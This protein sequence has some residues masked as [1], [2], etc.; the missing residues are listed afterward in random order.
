MHAASDSNDSQFEVLRDLDTMVGDNLDLLAPVDK[1]WQPTDFLP[2][3]AAEDWHQRLADFRA[4]AQQLSDE[5]LVIL[6]G[7]M[8]TEEALPNYAISLNLIA[9]DSQGT[10]T[11]PWA[12]WM[13]GW[14][15]EENRHG[16]LLNAFL[17]LTGRVDMRSVEV[18]VQHLLAN[19]F[20]PVARPDPYA[21][22]IYTSFQE[23]A[24]RISHFNVAKLARAEGNESLGR[25]CAR[26]AGDENRHATFY[27]RMVG[28][29]FDQDPAG[30][31]VIFRDMLR[32]IISMPGKLMYDGHDPDLFEHFAVV[33]QRAGVYTV[34]DYISIVAY[35]VDTWNIATR[36]LTDKAAKAQDFLC[37]HAERLTKMSEAVAEGVAKQP[38]RSF[39]WIHDRKA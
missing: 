25:I 13:R 21:G 18:T 27:T 12:R 28:H 5:V 10:S 32:R 2:D 8:V 37:R 30:A 36:S 17:R 19:G 24:T 6:V 16:D 22:M 34:Q 20:E 33:A 15:A 38:R 3:L 9:R 1:A 29:I 7:D 23:R 4:P 11:N 31:M 35:L 26:I 14:V 39:S